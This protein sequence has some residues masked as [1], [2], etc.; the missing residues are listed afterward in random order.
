MDQEQIR[1]A[2]RLQDARLRAGCDESEAATAAGVPIAAYR[3]WERGT[4]L[5]SLFQ[6]R[7]L[8]AHFGAIEYEVLH[9]SLP[10][11][12]SK[13]ESRELQMAAQL[14]SPGLRSRIDL[15]LAIFAEPSEAQPGGRAPTP[16][17]PADTP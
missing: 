8:M 10:L 7:D 16:A 3:A 13:A 11:R 1:L 15:V 5:P 9:G 2:G 17:A 6:L 14:F 4:T 12:F